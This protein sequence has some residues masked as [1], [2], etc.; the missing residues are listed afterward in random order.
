MR[1]CLRRDAHHLAAA[2]GDRPHIGVGKLVQHEQLAADRVD[3]VHRIGDREIEQPRAVEQPLGVLGQLEDLAA[4][5]A[6]ALE[7]AARIV[8]TVGQHVDLGVGPV[9]EGAVEPDL[10][11]HLSK[12]TPAIVCLLQASGALRRTATRFANAPMAARL[13]RS[14][15]SC[16]SSVGTSCSLSRI[17]SERLQG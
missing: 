6:L 8:Q 10:S 12:G 16:T 11:G 4:I 1:L 13:R 14:R 5:G 17:R 7:H 9:D 15:N 2:P 3:L